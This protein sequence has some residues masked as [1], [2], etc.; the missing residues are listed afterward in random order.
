MLFQADVSKSAD[1]KKMVDTCVKTYGR[2]DILHNNVGIGQ[3]KYGGP[4]DVEEADWDRVIDTNMKSMFLTCRAVLPQMVKQGRGAILNISSIAAIR[5]LYPYFI[6]IVSKAGVNA[7]T[8]S[9]AV[10]YADKG[11][12]VNA[13]R[14][15]LIDTP[16]ITPLKILYGGDME[17]MKR[18][19]AQNVP[20]K[21]MGEAWDI[22]YAALFLV[23]DEAKYITGQVLAVDGGLTCK[24]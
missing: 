12:R 10:E 4:P 3:S 2:L 17:R 13:I 7:L 8:R 24:V 22:A 11:I 15:G 23:S 5:V 14:P 19:R 6:Y 18:E 9:L 1:C 21:R 20:M 16:L